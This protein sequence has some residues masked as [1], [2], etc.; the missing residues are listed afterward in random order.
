[1]VV[2][3]VRILRLDHPRLGWA[4]NPMTGICIREKGEDRGMWGEEEAM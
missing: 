2:V 1:V 4:P 3:K